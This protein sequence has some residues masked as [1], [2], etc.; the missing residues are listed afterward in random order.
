MIYYIIKW[1][2]QAGSSFAFREEVVKLSFID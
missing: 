2:K 1:L